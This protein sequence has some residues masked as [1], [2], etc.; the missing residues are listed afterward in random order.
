MAEDVC[1]VCGCELRRQRRRWLFKRAGGPSRPSLDVVLS[2]L[3]GRQLPRDGSGEFVCSKC[4]FVLE[5]VYNYDTVMGRVKALSVQR[6]QRLALERDSL[7]R[8]LLFQFERQNPGTLSHSLCPSAPAHSNPGALQLDRYWAALNEDAAFSEYECWSERGSGGTV[9]STIGNCKA[10][11]TP[12]R[13]S[14]AEEL[15]KSQSVGNLRVSDARYEAVCRVPRIGHQI[16]M[17]TTRRALSH[18][19]LRVGGGGGGGGG[20]INNDCQ[21]PNAAY[22]SL[23]SRHR[24]NRPTNLFLSTSMASL[25]NVSD[26]H[27]TEKDET[28]DVIDSVSV[29]SEAMRSPLQHTSPL[30]PI[31]PAHPVVRDVF[32][33]VMAIASRP[34]PSTPS[35]KIPTPRAGRQ[36]VRGGAKRRFPVPIPHIQHDLAL[37]SKPELKVSEQLEQEVQQAQIELQ[38]L[39]HQLED[40]RSS[41]EVLQRESEEMHEEKENI[42]HRLSQ[43]DMLLLECLSIVNSV[44]DNEKQS[45]DTVC[46]L[47]HLLKDSVADEIPAVGPSGGEVARLQTLL[48]EKENDLQRL[49]EFFRS[50]EETIRDLNDSLRDKEHQLQYREET[51]KLLEAV[52]GSTEGTFE[53]R[54]QEKDRHIAALEAN[55]EELRKKGK[56]NGEQRERKRLQALLVEKDEQL[57][58]EMVRFYE[59]EEK[60]QRA[61]LD[62]KERVIQVERESAVAMRQQQATAQIQQLE[63][64]REYV[65]PDSLEESWNGNGGFGS[66]TDDFPFDHEDDDS[67]PEFCSLVPRTLKG[68]GNL[69]NK[70]VGKSAACMTPTTAVCS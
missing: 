63:L 35:S 57:Q 68:S 38:E 51:I 69:E 33:E 29:I 16:G 27:I 18:V 8:C 41:N 3:L 26:L 9:L 47:H 15:R 36:T 39:K 45:A 65:K 58:N 4:A 62:A 52:H 34:V 5:Q 24:L 61:L 28:G 2:H 1:R 10:P 66:T 32:N 20:V 40:A 50:T 23:L 55:L 56:G 67:L 49:N 59:A 6:M 70:R 44:K 46:S 12:T 11:V 42:A 60:H 22:G 53:R 64:E 19:S 48:Q 54:L 25:S 14:T 43:R 31:T 17:P 21:S 30:S 13:R 37:E 7:S